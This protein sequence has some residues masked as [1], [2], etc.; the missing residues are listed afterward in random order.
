MYKEKKNPYIS[1]YKKSY[2]LTKA[3]IIWSNYYNLNELFYICIL[4][5]IWIYF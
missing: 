2:M 3:A 4:F 5:I 1:I